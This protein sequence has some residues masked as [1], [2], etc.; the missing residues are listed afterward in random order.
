[1]L[2]LE[3]ILQQKKKPYETF[4]IRVGIYNNFVKTTLLNDFG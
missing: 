1:M 3:R 4:E 2:L